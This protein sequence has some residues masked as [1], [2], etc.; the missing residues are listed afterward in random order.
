[1]NQAI[2]EHIQYALYREMKDNPD[3]RVIDEIYVVA[4]Q[5]YRECYGD[6][7]AHFVQSLN[8]GRTFDFYIDSKKAPFIYFFL[9]YE[10][11]ALPKQFVQLIDSSLRWYTSNRLKA[12]YTHRVLSLTEQ[13]FSDGQCVETSKAYN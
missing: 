11:I 13:N 12:D 6:E 9:V 7:Y 1:M 4:K 5:Y 8:G 3:S 10:N 2:Y